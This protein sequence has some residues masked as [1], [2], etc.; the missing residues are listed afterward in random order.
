MYYDDFRKELDEL[1]EEIAM[2]KSEK[3]ASTNNNNLETERKSSPFDRPVV[4]Y[5]LKMNKINEFD[6]IFEAFKKTGIGHPNIMFCCDGNL[7]TAGGFIFK[8]K[9]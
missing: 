8:Y 7:K 6:S 4:Q 9:D 3:Y 5:D 1:W 2:L